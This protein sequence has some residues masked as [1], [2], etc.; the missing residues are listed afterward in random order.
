M[1]L[2]L[3]SRFAIEIV[4]GLADWEKQHYKELYA[5]DVFTHAV[6]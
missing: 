4:H 5:A 1:T 2:L 6:N 3:L